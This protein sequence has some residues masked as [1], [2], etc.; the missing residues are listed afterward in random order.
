MKF[1]FGKNVINFDQPKGLMT[2]NEELNKNQL[3]GKSRSLCDIDKLQKMK[4]RNRNNKRKDQTSDKINNKKQKLVKYLYNQNN[5]YN[6]G[7]IINEYKV[8]NKN[9]NINKKET[10]EQMDTSITDVTCSLFSALS[11]KKDNDNVKISQKNTKNK[12][13]NKIRK[14]E[15]SPKNNIRYNASKNIIPNNDAI[16]VK[17]GKN[18]KGEN[19]DNFIKHTP[20]SKPFLKIYNNN[21]NNSNNN[22]IQLEQNYLEINRSENNIK[23]LRINKTTDEKRNPIKEKIDFP[24]Y[25]NLNSFNNVN[26]QYLN[27]SSFNKDNQRYLKSSN[28]FININ[29]QEKYRIKDISVNLN[30]V[31]YNQ[32]SKSRDISFLYKN[33]NKR[34]INMKREIT[35]NIETESNIITNN[36]DFNDFNDEKNRTPRRNNITNR[37][38]PQILL[39]AFKKEKSELA[40][41]F[42]REI[43]QNQK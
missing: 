3:L 24:N 36:S 21:G 20:N 18:N 34:K 14:D 17:T 11:P 43:Y 23:Y 26:N 29:D 4:N 27:V 12:I 40:A 42:R 7:N 35:S 2:N 37:C 16:K 41:S 32:K 10:K 31:R 8:T 15:R 6:Y 38:K 5:N 9:V 1:P 28:S 19:I 39:K 25:Y 33:K 13:T 30:K 22:D